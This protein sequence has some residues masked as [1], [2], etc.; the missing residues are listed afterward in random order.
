MTN[1]TRSRRGSRSNA[2]KR[3]KTS[4]TTTAPDA[5]KEAAPSELET[6]PQA[7]KQHLLYK[8]SESAPDGFHGYKGLADG[9]TTKACIRVVPPQA[10]VNG[11]INWTHPDITH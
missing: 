9:T 6:T 1:R 7:F 10:I 5:E 2:A 8:G 3:A 4:P 11:I